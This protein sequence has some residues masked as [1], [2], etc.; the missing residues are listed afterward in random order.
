MTAGNRSSTLSFF[1]FR[2]CLTKNVVIADTII[3]L[4]SSFTKKGKTMEKTIKSLSQDQTRLLLETLRESNKPLSHKCKCLRNHC[5]ALLMLDAGLRVGELVGLVVE[6]LWY[7]N[8]PRAALTLRAEI[9]KTK[10]ERTIPLSGRLK[11]AIELMGKYW[12]SEYLIE[13][14]LPA[15]TTSFSGER[16]T[17]RQVQRI[18]G[19]ASEAAIGE[20]IHPHTLRHTFATRLMRTTNIRIVQELLGH[21]SITSTQVYTHPN[22]D[23]LKNAIDAIG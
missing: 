4:M 23:D 19:D 18:I 9:T 15:F 11:E 22:T 20:R 17:I 1:L 8:A 10:R 12:W 6:D 7:I 3:N 5:M 14:Q 13:G 21:V 2:F 16:L